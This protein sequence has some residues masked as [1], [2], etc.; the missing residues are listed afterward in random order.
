M[1]DTVWEKVDEGLFFVDNKSIIRAVNR[2]AAALLECERADLIDKPLRTVLAPEPMCHAPLV[3]LWHE[4]RGELLHID[5]PI[6]ECET[7]SGG[8]YIEAT[9][10]SL[11]EDEGAAGDTLIR[12]CDVTQR[13]QLLALL[14]YDQRAESV[15]LLIGNISHNF[16]NL[17]TSVLGQTSLAMT[18]LAIDNPAMSNIRKAIQA[19]KRAANLNHQLLAFAGNTQ[20]DST[21][22]I[23]ALLTNSVDL[24]ETALAHDIHLNLELN[25]S[26]PHV[27]VRYAQ[28]QQIVVN[29]VINA[30]EAVALK[31]R[32][33]GSI[34]DGQIVLRTRRVDVGAGDT[35]AS[36]SVN[37][38]TNSSIPAVAWSTGQTMGETNYDPDQR[39]YRHLEQKAVMA[40][41]FGVPAPGQYVCLDIIDDGIGIEAKDLRH[42]CEPLWS[43]KPGRR[44]MGLPV[45]HTIV[46]RKGGALR[47]ESLPSEGSCF[48]VLLPV[49]DSANVVN[50]ITSN[51]SQDASSIEVQTTHSLRGIVLLIEPEAAQRESYLDIVEELGLSAIWATN[52]E[53]GLEMIDLYKDHLNLVVADERMFVEEGVD[54]V[55]VVAQ[56]D[57]P[58]R[59]ILLHDAK[60][61]A[62][63]HSHY[64]FVHH[65]SKR[66]EMT[67]LRSRIH[68]ALRSESE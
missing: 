65:V 26:L 54:I 37:S 63:V 58:L 39:F 41:E 24:L 27:A 3:F 20:T 22:E 48:S 15:G 40:V 11:L 66:D 18:K 7:H 67:E 16:N 45:V 50:S 8:R 25:S 52:T 60:D 56:H 5:L 4:R 28:V 30:S 10:V 1:L 23:N 43:T 42:I 64:P 14:H 62:I 55:E 17:L 32:M 49:V 59:L 6:E 38:S 12:L 57:R 44:G 68:Q 47:V 51:N 9:R 21:T 35:S 29:L 34:A 2:R 31:Q 13:E 61:G 33:E 36:N 19:A 53:Q 46:R